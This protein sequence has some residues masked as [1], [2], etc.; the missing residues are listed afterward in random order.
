MSRFRILKEL[1]KYLKRKRRHLWSLGA[2]VF[3]F[4]L[5]SLVGTWSAHQIITQGAF[6]YQAVPADASVSIG[7]DNPASEEVWG[8]SIRD[9]TIHMLQRWEGP[10]EVTLHR[11]YLCGDETRQLGRHPT[12]VALELLK[13]HRDWGAAFDSTGVLIMEQSIDDLSPQCRKTAYIAMDSRGNLSL[14]DGPPRR[15]KVIRTFFQLDIDRLE[16][17]MSQD[18]MLELSNGIRIQDK[19]EYNRILSTFNEFAILK[20]Q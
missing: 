16:S 18:R 12:S 6:Q 3:L 9:R 2:G 20:S 17:Q 13:S 4:V 8:L 7:M 14:Y 19:D 15:E 11:T 10:I 5:A 1:K